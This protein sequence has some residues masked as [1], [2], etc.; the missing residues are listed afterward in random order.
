MTVKIKVPSDLL[1]EDPSAPG[2]DEI[3]KELD[4]NRKRMAFSEERW[5]YRV[6]ITFIF[7]FSVMGML[8][9]AIFLFHLVA[10]ESWRW[11][12]ENELSKIKELTLSI[13]VGLIMSSSTVYFFRRKLKP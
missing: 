2:G 6:K 5:L 9:V 7:C 4:G 11:L 8:A 12:T 1:P 3:D 13:I 10:P